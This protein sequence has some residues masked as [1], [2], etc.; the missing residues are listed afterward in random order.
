VSEVDT[1]VEQVFYREVHTGDLAPY[2]PLPVVRET[3]DF[4]R[5]AVCCFFV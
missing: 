5:F 3:L 1:G 2:F 4:V